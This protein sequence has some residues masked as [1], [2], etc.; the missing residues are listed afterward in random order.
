MIKELRKLYIIHKIRKGEKLTETEINGVYSIFGD[1]FV[2]SID[3]LS[4]KTDIS[5]DDIVGIV[6]KFIGIDDVELNK[7]FE[8]FIQNH[9]NKMNAT[10]I[11]TLEIIK[12]DIAKNKGISVKA[13]FREPY[14]TF[15]P[16]GVEGIFGRMADDVFDLIKPFKATYI[17]NATQ[18]KTLEIIKNDIAK[19]KGI[20]VKA[21]FRE[22]YTTFNP[23]GV[24]GIFGRMADDVFDLIKPFK[25]TYIS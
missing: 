11:K 9:H 25:A 7:I 12:N 20:S 21:L 2:Y 23:D 13:L 24:E 4:S 19:N 1:D 16:D 10:Q 6:R 5:K 3:E 22:P 15:N 17:S 18:I 8:E 14:T